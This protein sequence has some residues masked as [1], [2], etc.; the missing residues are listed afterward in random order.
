MRW[1]KAAGLALELMQVIAA[2]CGGRRYNWQFHFS[3]DDAAHVLP[4][5]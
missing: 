4:G 3:A 2:R 1:A 5:P